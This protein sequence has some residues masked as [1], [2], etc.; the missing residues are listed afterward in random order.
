M[1]KKKKKKKKRGKER[2]LVS[3]KWRT[4][5]REVGKKDNYCTQSYYFES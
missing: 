2:E 5:K 3:E 1:E 4:K